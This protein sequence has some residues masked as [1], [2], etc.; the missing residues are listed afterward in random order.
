[1]LGQIQDAISFTL[2]E[3][4]RGVFVLI[5]K[6]KNKPMIS[7]NT[8]RRNSAS[9]KEMA[10]WIWPRSDAIRLLNSPTLRSVK[11]LIGMVSSLL[12]TSLRRS[13]TERS[14]TEVSRYTL[15][16]ENRVWIVSWQKISNKVVLRLQWT[17]L[18]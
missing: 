14:P 12:K 6:M 10:S 2:A 9:V 17:D 1:D 5:R 16:N 7:I 13:A 11:K 18:R 8:P 4:L 3:F 15:I